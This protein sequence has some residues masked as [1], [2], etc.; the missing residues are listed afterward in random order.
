MSAYK[1]ITEE[2]CEA[3]EYENET[4]KECNAAKV[5]KA[6]RLYEELEAVEK[7]KLAGKKGCTVGELDKLLKDMIENA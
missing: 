5:I 2:P 3:V 4:L 6:H 7:D 1:N